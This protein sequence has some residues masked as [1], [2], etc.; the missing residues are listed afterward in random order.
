MQGN[1]NAEMAESTQCKK[2][3]VVYMTEEQKEVVCGIF[4][5]H[6][7]D[8]DYFDGDETVDNQASC[9]QVVSR[10]ECIGQSSVEERVYTVSPERVLEME[11]SC[12]CDSQVNDKSENSS[13][14]A[15]SANDNC[16][17]C[18]NSPCVTITPQS[19]LGSGHPPRPGNNLIRKKIY[20]KY[21]TMLD[22]RGL[23]SN[24]LYLKRKQRL[25]Q[26]AHVHLTV[27]EIMPE[28]VLEQVRG[29]YPN[30]KNIPYMGHFW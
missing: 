4:N 17:Y 11:P 6:G 15:T 14:T 8:F 5:F 2:K 9:E 23:W 10:S 7:W 30:P 20:R 25:M 21:W 18:L 1:L 3:Y 24:P 22:R 16:P 26:E 27:R 13:E 29:L 28:C 12:S 19:W